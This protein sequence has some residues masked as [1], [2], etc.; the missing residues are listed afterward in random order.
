MK[1]RQKLTKQQHPLKPIQISG[2]GILL[3]FIAEW[4][5][6]QPT[7]IS[8]PQKRLFFTWIC[9][10]GGSIWLQRLELIYAPCQWH[11]SFGQ[12]TSHLY[13]D[14]CCKLCYY[15]FCRYQ[16][17][18]K[19][20]YTPV[21]WY[22]P[23]PKSCA[24]SHTAS[25]LRF[26]RHLQIAKGG[27]WQ[28]TATHNDIVDRDEYELHGVANE[29]WMFSPGWRCFRSK[30]TDIFQGTYTETQESHICT[31]CIHYTMKQY[32][33]ISVLDMWPE[34]KESKRNIA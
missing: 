12:E 24:Q 5:S 8:T 6:Q 7:Y 15:I 32:Y 19:K 9:E 28:L 16:N 10:T 21:F 29:A 26:I 13:L 25:R 23:Y 17:A 31:I 1:A 22:V 27:T 4:K 14:H 34:P 11:F 2:Y 18:R 3:W 33:T 30:R 20:T